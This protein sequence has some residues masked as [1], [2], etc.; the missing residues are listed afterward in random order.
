M[1]SDSTKAY[2]KFT[3]SGQNSS[4]FEFF[5][6]RSSSSNEISAA[7]RKCLILFIVLRCNE[8]DERTDLLDFI[9]RTVPVQ[10]I[11]DTEE[12]SNGT[13]AARESLRKRRRESHDELA[14]LKQICENDVYGK[15]DLEIPVYFSN[16]T[17]F[18]RTVHVFCE[19]FLPGNLPCFCDSAFYIIESQ[20][21][22]VPES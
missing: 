17:K 11:L 14:K 1:R 18:S 2:N 3:R 22:Y 19:V 7:G 10:A 5:C 16:R 8:A 13:D 6:L 4:S 12:S 15:I 21:N 20:R 9:R